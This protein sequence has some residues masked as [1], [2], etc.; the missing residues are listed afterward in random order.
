MCTQS[1][2]DR[3]N[4]NKHKSLV[5]LDVHELCGYLLVHSPKCYL[6]TL[7]AYLMVGLVPQT[8]G[9]L[10]TQILKAISKEESNVTF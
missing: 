4:R 1:L 8:T 3:Y 10:A 2:I 9:K 5:T 6:E 7:S